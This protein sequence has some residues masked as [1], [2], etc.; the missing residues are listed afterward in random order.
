MGEFGRITCIADLPP[1]RTLM[2]YIRKAVA[3]REAG[4]WRP[5]RFKHPPPRVPDDLAAALKA[6]P[7][8][9][10]VFKRF[11]PSH[12]REY[13]EWLT[14]AKKPETRARRLATTIEWLLAGKSRNWKYEHGAERSR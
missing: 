12:R 7:R 10:L 6:E 2:A 11:P 1:R 3:L 8:A 9:A 14:E 4:V 5:A 13:I